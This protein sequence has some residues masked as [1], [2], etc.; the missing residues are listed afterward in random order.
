VSDLLYE[1]GQTRPQSV[2]HP[3]SALTAKFSI[4]ILDPLRW[5]AYLV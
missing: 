4:Q 5:P 3:G 1:V 2:G